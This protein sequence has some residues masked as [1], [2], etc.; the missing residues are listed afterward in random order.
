MNIIFILPEADFKRE[1]CRPISYN[2]VMLL[3]PALQVIEPIPERGTLMEILLGDDR[4]GE[5]VT[6]MI[7]TQL[8]NILRDNSRFLT[9]FAPTDAAF[10]NAPPAV[11][12]R[13]LEDKDILQ[14]I[15][16]LFK[17]FFNKI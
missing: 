3:F 8:G 7:V 11:V 4:F 13:I 5:L 6:A 16:L 14:S 10:R 15:C 9:V 2:S 1:A 17:A 12:E